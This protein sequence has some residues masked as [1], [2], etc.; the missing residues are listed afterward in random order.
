MTATVEQLLLAGGT[1][2]EVEIPAHVLA[3]G[4]DG[5]MPARVVIRPL[6]L[7]DVQR[8]QKAGREGAALTSALMVSQALVE[9][10]LTLDQ[11]GR[12]HAGLVELL[13]REVNR[14]SG[15]A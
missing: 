5:E 12:L 9:P 11:V 10:K 7:A 8:I 4:G 14:I 3:P 1:T 2:H 15:L 13:L 6:L